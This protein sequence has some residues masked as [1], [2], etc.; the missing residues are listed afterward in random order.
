VAES[1][2]DA[3]AA[4]AA[5]ARDAIAAAGHAGESPALV[6]LTSAPGAEEDVLHGIQDVVGADVPIVGGSAADNTVEGHWRQ[7]A[8]GRTY[9]DGVVATAM[10]PSTNTYSAFR[11]GYYPTDHTGRVTRASK[12]TIHTINRRPAA[13]VYNE[14]TG[15]VIKDHLSGGNVLDITTLHPIGRVAKRIGEMVFYR[16][17]HPETVTPEGGLTLFSDFETGDEVVLMMGSRASLVTR[18]GVVAQSALEFG[19]ISPSR[20]AGGLVIYCAGCMLTVQDQMDDVAASVRQALG[21]NPF[22]G[23][24]TFGEQGCFVGGGNHHGNLM[25]SMLAFERG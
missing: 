16:L 3:R 1:G 19:S 17:A 7:F 22:L 24:F 12:R 11:S 6:W 9:T 20:I 23:V 18:A 4:G 14:W 8:N 13:E 25:I 21:G 2:S 15:G 5:A 10:Y